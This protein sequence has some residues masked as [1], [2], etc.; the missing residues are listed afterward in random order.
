VVVDPTT[1]R[2]TD[3]IVAKGFLL[4]SDK[5]L[6]VHA[7]EEA[8]DK[9]IT[10]SMGKR[11]LDNCPEYLDVAFEPAPP[12]LDPDTGEPTQRL[13]WAD[14]E[15][16]YYLLPAIPLIRRHVHRGLAPE[17]VAIGRGTPVYNAEDQIGEV[18]HVLV[19]PETE[20][21]T[22]VV[23]DPG[24]ASHSLVVP[25]SMVQ[26]VAEEGLYLQATDTELQQLYHYS[27]PSDDELLANLRDSLGVIASGLRDIELT[28]GR[29]VVRLTGVVPDTEAKRRAEA[30]ARSARGVVHVEN[31]LGTDAAIAAR[32]TVAL[33]TDSRRRR[34]SPVANPVWSQC[35]TTWRSDR[36][37]TR[38][39]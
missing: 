8:S 20:E 33:M 30:T 13:V 6:P 29:G 16:P 37:S 38:R 18:D 4:T 35:S 1:N 3:L 5:V 34:R 7:V 14:P 23:V 32:V 39:R 21:I 27:C 17:E 15:D 9:G 26:T 10:V 31:A 19:N 22:Y 24:P 28:V 36:T 2:I 25:V 11:E 12:D